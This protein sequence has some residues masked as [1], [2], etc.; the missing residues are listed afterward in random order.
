LPVR[1]VYWGPSSR[2]IAALSSSGDV[3]PAAAT[4]MSS[5]P[6][7][8][9]I[10]CASG[11]VISTIREPARLS[12]SPSVAMPE[13]LYC[14]FGARPDTV[15]VS[16]TLKPYFSAVPRSSTTSPSDC[17]GPPSR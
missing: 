5:K 4:E 13:T 8:P 17:G 7:W 6:S 12:E 1:T 2:A 9:D 16:P 15:T 11:S 3:P 14:F 10:R